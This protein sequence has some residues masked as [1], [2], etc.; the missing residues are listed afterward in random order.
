MNSQGKYMGPDIESI[1]ETLFNELTEFT[2]ES[3]GVSVELLQ[4]FTTYLEDYEHQF[5]IEWLK[6]IKSIL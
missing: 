6:D 4:H 2:E 3:L 5:Y 1:N